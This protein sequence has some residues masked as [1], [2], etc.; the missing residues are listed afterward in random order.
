M[1]LSEVACEIQKTRNHVHDVKPGHKFKWETS[2][3]AHLHHPVTV[4]C[5]SI[6]AYQRWTVSCQRLELLTNQALSKLGCISKMSDFESENPARSNPFLRGSWSC[7][8][9]PPFPSHAPQIQGIAPRSSPPAQSPP[10]T[11]SVATLT[12]TFKAAVLST[13]HRSSFLPPM[14]IP[15]PLLLSPPWTLS[16]AL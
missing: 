6:A 7:T 10:P 16:S 3:Q 11:S 2:L 13:C 5:A 9:G 4:S 14:F 15:T 12:S 1:L 8:L